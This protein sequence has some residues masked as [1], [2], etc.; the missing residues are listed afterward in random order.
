MY[1]LLS[2]PIRRYIRDKRWEALRPIQEAAIKYILSTEK[3]YILASRTASGKTEAAFLPVLS[4]VNF[5]ETGVRVLYISPLIALINDQFKRVEELC[6]YLDVPVTKWHGEANRTLKEK[7]IKSPSG[8]VLIT[9][10]S[11]E[12]MF[13]NAPQHIAHL[14]G[15]LE[16]VIIDEI[17]AFAGT[18]RGLQLRAILSRL[19]FDMKRPFRVVGL[20]ATIGDFQQVKQLTADMENTTVL[21]DIR[22]KEM[23]ATFKFFE[24]DGADLPQELI[25]DVYMETRQQQVLA[26]PNSRG[27]AEELA[28]RLKKVADRQNGHPYY[29]SHHSSVNR[30]LR[31]Y[32][33][34]FVKEN[35]RYPFLIACTST[36]ELG[37]DIG[38]VD[39]VLQIDAPH[40]IASLV[41][42][43]GRSGRTEGVQSNLLCYATGPW[44][45][46][47][48][49]ACLQL[50]REEFI[51]PAVDSR[52]A[53]DI[54]LHQLLS[55]IKQL[56][57]CTLP[58]LMQRLK[59]IEVF[60]DIDEQTRLQIMQFLIDTDMLERLGQELIIGV[61][62]E[63]VVNSKDFYSVFKSEPNYRVVHQDKT[64]GEIPLLS[65][66]AVDENILLAAK[67][68]KVLDIDQ[69]AKKIS[70]QPTK[71][72][73]KPKFFGSGG[74]LHSRVREKM[75]EL[76]LQEQTVTELDEAA[77]EALRQL[78]DDFSHYQ[79]ED[80]QYDRPVLIKDGS[81]TWY[82]FQGSKINRTLHFL[83]RLVGTEIDYD[84]SSSSFVIR[85]GLA[86]LERLIS[87]AITEVS[88][89]DAHLA[90]CLGQQPDLIDFSK[91][92]IYLPFPLR[93]TLLK[94]KYYDFTNALQFLKNQR[95]VTLQ[96]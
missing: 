67:I 11:L 86:E 85:G 56:A 69:K 77:M 1:E 95:L 58:A 10:E 91:W 53:Y 55:T 29:F 8:V 79:I 48:S 89:I 9:P 2:E 12:A 40:S 35:R 13:V 42:R 71:D 22:A 7:L 78:R 31:E 73:R 76:L 37:I 65:I 19:K 26:F 93:C 14:F 92:G 52:F 3:N 62:G 23:S 24:M 90:T 43:T 50:Y 34:H 70:V 54:L 59:A 6:A 15:N 82:S 75:L 46:L 81:V 17:H 32:I 18:D 83:F 5:R 4:K 44:S 84:D 66:I 72:G 38:S 39:R 68:W 57:G 74:D 87:K 36:L 60:D 20:S 49:L 21:R 25:D 94:L 45:L 27:R 30:E 80:L 96:K 88:N 28:V 64:I 51:E 41:Q 47:Q 16:F 33:E 63:R 61:E